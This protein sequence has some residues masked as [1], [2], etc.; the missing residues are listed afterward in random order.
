MPIRRTVL[1]AASVGLVAGVLGGALVEVASHRHSIQ[2]GDAPTTLGAVGAI[3]AV[4]YAALAFRQQREDLDA[5]GRRQARMDRQLTY[6]AHRQAREAVA[7]VEC[8][9]HAGEHP[10]EEPGMTVA[11]GIAGD[12]LNGSTWSIKDIAFLATVGDVQVQP[13]Q[14]IWAAYRDGEWE[15]DNARLWTPEK[16]VPLLNPQ[17]GVRYRWIVP[18]VTDPTAA[19]VWIRFTDEVNTRWE[20]D[21][22]GSINIVEEDH[23]TW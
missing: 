5:L 14:A 20:R 8:A 13:V 19:K 21:P 11:L 7:K 10:M 4:I 15:Y 2:W 3:G 16:P 6:E 23:L 1:I 9:V 18:E 22:D 17:F 12:V